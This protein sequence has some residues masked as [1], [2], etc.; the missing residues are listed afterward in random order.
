MTGFADTLGF[1]LVTQGIDVVFNFLRG[2]DGQVFT[3]SADNNHHLCHGLVDQP[4]HLVQVNVLPGGEVLAAFL[5]VVDAAGNIVAG[6][7][8]GLQFANLTEHFTNLTL[9]I[10][11]Q[12]LVTDF[13]QVVGDFQLHVVGNILV[14]P[15]VLVL[16][17][18]FLSAFL[19]KQGT[20]HAEHSLHSFC[21]VDDFLL[22]LK[23]GD[24]WRGHQSVVDILQTANAL[25]LLRIVL[26]DPLHNALHL[27]DETDEQ[28]GVGY[29]K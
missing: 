9:C 21:K 20:R 8:D 29:I 24:F 10:L 2:V 16:L 12:V 3:P 7:T 22:R 5:A 14:L 28:Q 15:D 27:R 19:V 17:G 11:R 13:L 25:G 18:R 1:E 23:D 6:I 4:H 26:V